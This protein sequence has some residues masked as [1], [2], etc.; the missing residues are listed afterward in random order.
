M[1]MATVVP[2]EDSHEWLDAL[3]DE[4]ARRDDAIARLHALLLRAARFEVR[5]RRAGLP[6]L[7]G[8][9]LDDLAMQS[10]DDALVAVL[11][12]LDDFRG[13]SRF[14]TWAYKFA[15]LEAAVRLRRMSWQGREVPLPPDSWAGIAGDPSSPHADAET[16]ELLEALRVAIAEQLTP[17]QRDVLVSVALNGVP[18]DVLAERLG[19]SRGALYK[20]LHDARQKLRR[21]LADQDLGI[22]EVG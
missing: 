19:S 7:R 10:A 14:T 5:R 12:K 17:R 1:A 11:A 2:M 9:P 4:G 21:C 8:G 18:I 6:H 15:L 16:R 22:E 20:T 3:R 13:E